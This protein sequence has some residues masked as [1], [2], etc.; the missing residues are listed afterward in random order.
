MPRH[1]MARSVKEYAFVQHDRARRPSV[2]GNGTCACIPAGHAHRAAA[3]AASEL[4]RKPRLEEAIAAHLRKADLTAVHGRAP[5]LA[6]RGWR[7]HRGLAAVWHRPQPET[8]VGVRAAKSA[9]G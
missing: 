6:W 8:A 1:R 4:L 3:S 9:P 7:R 5:A 2:R